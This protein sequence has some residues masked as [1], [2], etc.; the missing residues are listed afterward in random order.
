VSALRLPAL[1]AAL[2]GLLACAEPAPPHVVLF[3]ADTLRADHLSLSGYPRRTSPQVDAFA[4]GAW[5]FE[6]AITV[7]P[8]TGPSF[9]TLFSGRHPRE[10]GVHSNFGDLPEDIPLLA[11]RLKAAGYR[12]AGFVENPALRASRGFG[13]GFDVYR[14]VLS[15]SRG[16]ER[17]LDAW[18]EWAEADW[19]APTFVW[20][21]TLDPHGPYRPPPEYERLFVG[22][23]WSGSD[24]RVPLLPGAG[25][26]FKVLGAIPKYQQRGDEDRVARYVAWYDAEIRLIDDAFGRVLEA[27]RA[28]GLYE[29]AAVIFTSDHGESLGE[30]DYY[31]EHGWY[32]YEPGLRIPLLIKTPGQTRGQRVAAPVSNLDFFR[33]I[34]GL[35]GI[36][37]PPGVGGRDLLA[38]APPDR[39]ILVENSGR[40]EEKYFGLRGASEKYLRREGDGREELY[41]LSADPGE[42]RDLSAERPDRTRALREQL[43]RRL[44][45]LADDARAPLEPGDDDAETLERLR[46]LGYGE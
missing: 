8:K 20:V 14:V 10:H 45:E 32:A 4:A 26:A 6:Q 31:F 38:G 36:E 40:Y 35:T 11:E 5:H 19:D 34:A 2:L 41:D 21:H 1:G 30:H 3:T 9:A 42:L 13:R 37:V 33:T 39:V 23:R 46:A 7:V 18:L 25:R 15:G 16:A 29:E 44:A 28:R 17:L 43:E 27:L 12:T 22:D 24:E